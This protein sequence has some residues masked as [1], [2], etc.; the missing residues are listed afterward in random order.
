MKRHMKVLGGA[1]LLAGALLAFA[2]PAA[3]QRRSRVTKEDELD[4]RTPA[5]RR[6]ARAE[7]LNAAQ[8]VSELF[9]CESATTECR[10]T[11]SAFT[12]GK[13]RD[14]F[15]FVTW[16]STNGDRV[17]TVEFFLPDG[18]L[19]M[20]RD[21]AFRTRAGQPRARAV[22]GAAVVADEYLTS[23][24]GMP[25]V[26]TPLAVAGTYITQRNLLGT[27]AVRVLL[28]GKPVLTGQFTLKTAD[29]E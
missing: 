4:A 21:T 29:Q 17:Q 5:D 16:P 19:Y 6:E 2:A 27:W 24:R 28:D 13:L 26:V 10:S 23:S 11:N 15:V 25:T 20:K 1:I 12:V 9:F 7:S 22:T 14:L 8:A 3:A 18:S